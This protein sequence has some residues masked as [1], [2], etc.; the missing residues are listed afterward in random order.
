MKT[1][2]FALLWGNLLFGNVSSG[3][4]L[5]QNFLCYFSSTIILIDSATWHVYMVIGPLDLYFLVTTLAEL[6]QQIE[7]SQ[8]LF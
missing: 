3:S 2:L 6:A 5:H 1:E 8:K 7:N 4:L